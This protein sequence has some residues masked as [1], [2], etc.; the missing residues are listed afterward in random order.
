MSASPTSP[1]SASVCANQ[2]CA[3]RVTEVSFRTLSRATANA[4]AP[5]PSAGR[6]LKT[7]HASRQY[8][9]RD[10]DAANTRPPPC[11]GATFVSLVSSEM[12][13]PMPRSLNATD[14]NAASGTTHAT[15]TAAMPTLRR[16]RAEGTRRAEPASI[17][18]PTSISR[19]S[20]RST[21]VPK[22]PATASFADSGWSA[23]ENASFESAH[24]ATATAAAD[25]KGSPPGG[26]AA[27]AARARTRRS[28]PSRRPPPR[29]A[30]G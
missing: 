9:P 29:R 24:A 6:A 18:A 25:G 16:I 17:A 20:I 22:S 2:P 28:R 10:E 19:A 13:S 8:L 7:L 21:S 1:K 3:W 23:F 27:A 15:T 30:T 11:C 12:R 5:T 26:S 4:P 14:V